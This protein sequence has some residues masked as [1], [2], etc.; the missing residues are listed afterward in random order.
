MVRQSGYRG[1]RV[2]A[3]HF[4]QRFFDFSSRCTIPGLWLCAL[5]TL[6]SSQSVWA[7][8]AAST[9]HSICVCD[10]LQNQRQYRDPV[11]TCTT[12]RFDFRYKLYSCAAQDNALCV[13]FRRRS[14]T[15]KHC[16]LRPFFLTSWPED[17]A[18]D[19]LTSR[20]NSHPSS[21]SWPQSPQPLAPLL[22][23][24]S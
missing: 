10:R 19:S 11:K 14:T 4:F 24:V 22:C 5:S 8:I 6:H 2:S 20:E 21:I 3:T 9:I 12:L 7:N 13:R 23:R 18:T 16:L 17:S 1:I 15:P